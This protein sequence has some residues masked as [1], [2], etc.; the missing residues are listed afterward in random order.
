VQLSLFSTPVSAVCML[1]YDHEALYA[2]NLMVGFSGLI[3]LAVSLN[4]L[5]G[6]AVSMA[7]KCVGPSCAHHAPAVPAALLHRYRVHTHPAPPRCTPAA[8][9]L[10]P[11][12]PLHTRCARCTPAAPTT[13]HPLRP[14]YADN[15]QK[16][17]AVGISIVL[18]C[19]VR[20]GGVANDCTRSA[21]LALGCS[22]Y[23]V[24]RTFSLAH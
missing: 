14:R 18:N 23:V 17:F 3:W 22:A 4:A 5:G 11:L 10:R 8:H 7:L 1:L 24:V 16:T 21:A 13:A 12:R 19:L 2:R 9:P 6:I 20:G 15:I